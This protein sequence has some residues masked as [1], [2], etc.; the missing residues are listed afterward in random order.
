[1]YCNSGH[2]KPD[3]FQLGQILI[4]NKG[5]D[6][7]RNNASVL[8]NSLFFYNELSIFLNISQYINKISYA[9]VSFSFL[10]GQSVQTLRTTLVID[11]RASQEIP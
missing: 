3:D 1:M 9:T 2:F 8:R 6:L 7:P 11:E 4:K 10:K 5:S